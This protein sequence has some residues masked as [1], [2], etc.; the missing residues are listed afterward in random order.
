MSETVGIITEAAALRVNRESK[1][2]LLNTLISAL[3]KK[4]A[5]LAV[6]TALE[7]IVTDRSAANAFGDRREI[8]DHFSEWAK[9][10]AEVAKMWLETWEHSG[11]FD[12][13]STMNGA[14]AME[15]RARLVTAMIE[16]HSS[17]LSGF[18][19]ARPPLERSS[20]VK[21]A[22]H[23]LCRLGGESAASGC[24]AAIPFIREFVTEGERHETLAKIPGN[25]G[26]GL[27]Q[28][29]EYT[30]AIRFFEKAEMTPEEKEIIARAKIE[31]TLGTRR[32]PFD[33]AVEARVLAEARSFL[34]K[35]IPEREH[36]ILEE[37][38]AKV[39]QVVLRN[40]E[41]KIRELQGKPDATDDELAG[42]LTQYDLQ[43]QLDEAMKIAERIK[44]PDKRASTLAVLN[45]Q[46]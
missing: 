25:L 14:F 15:L 16:G 21:G 13:P 10:D 41:T 29:D 5:R 39:H 34:L 2:K 43:S 3:A 4:D 33:P 17:G 24:A 20:L 38:R 44:D 30:T 42:V 9:E 40:A 35:V 45:K 23:S 27:S 12:D 7:V 18:L 11:N 1:G 19:S 46:R 6:T 32:T 8:M 22:I 37:V 31:L 28:E 26:G 36:G